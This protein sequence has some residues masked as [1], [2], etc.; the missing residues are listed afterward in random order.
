MITVTKAEAKMI[1]KKFPRAH[2]VT[3][4]HKTMVDET[5]DVLEALTNNVD[6]QEA[7]AEME[8]DERRRT[9]RTLGDEVVA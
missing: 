4:V 3:T 5:R 7:L 9:A 2:M 8:Q 6:A 1:R